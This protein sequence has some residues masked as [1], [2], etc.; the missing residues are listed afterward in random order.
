MGDILFKLESASGSEFAL[1][2]THEEVVTP[3]AQK[4]IFSYKDL[5]V[6]VYQIQTK[7]RNEPR[8]KSGLLRGREFRMKD[9]YSFHTTEEDLDAYYEIVSGAYE[10]IWH[11]LGLGD[12]TVKTFASGGAFSKYSH[13]YQTLCPTGE[14]TVY[15]CAKCHLAVNKE[16]IAEQKTCPECGSADLQ[17]TKA[18][19]VG[20]IFKL[21]TKFSEPFGLKY[22]DALGQEQLVFMGC[23]GIGPSRLMGTIVEVFHD[24]KGIIWPE[25]VAPYKYHLLNLSASAKV[26]SEADDLY[27]KLV[28]KGEEVLYD[29]RAGLSAGA[30]FADAD[31]LGLPYRLVISDKTNGQVEFKKR[32]EPKTQ[33]VGFSEIINS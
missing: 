9:L 13:E 30:K 14:D 24:D 32:N 1:G 33:L 25:S 21:K 3:L 5:P 15:L 22:K 20:N 7:F 28:K 19:E 12:L 29:D 18:I 31:L 23:Y 26:K 11:R 16:I 17:E 6:Y 27:D 2:P 8:A 4:F 10:K